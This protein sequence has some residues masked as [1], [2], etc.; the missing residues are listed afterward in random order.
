MLEKQEQCNNCENVLPSSFDI[1]V[2]MR[3]H[4]NSYNNR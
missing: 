3:I 4:N 2:E 1:K